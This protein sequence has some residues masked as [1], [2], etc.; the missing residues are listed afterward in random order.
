MKNVKD[1]KE[2]IIFTGDVAFSGYFQNSDN[3]CAKQILDFL[4]SLVKIKTIL[5]ILS[6]NVLLANILLM[7][8]QNCLMVFFNL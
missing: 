6:L 2:T 3:I 4:H 5:Y 8:F 7:N 1:K